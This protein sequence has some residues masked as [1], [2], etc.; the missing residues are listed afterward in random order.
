MSKNH[1]LGLAICVLSSGLLAA[2]TAEELVAKNT[3]AKGGLAK[4]K[5]IRTLRMTGKIQS[6]SFV[7]KVRVDSMR[8]EFLRQ[9][10]TIQGMSAIEAYDGSSG[11][12]ISPFE[13]RKDPELLGEDD[14]KPLIEEADFYGPLIDYKEK[15]NRIEYLG[16]DS[17]DGDDAYR[18]KVTLHNGDIIYYYLDPDTYLE[19]RTEKQV[20]V[21]GAVRESFMEYGSYKKVAGVY[22]PFSLE[23]GSKENAGFRSKMTLDA[24]EAN[25]PMDE[26]E[27]RMPQTGAVKT[28]G[29]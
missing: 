21:R 24:I 9:S 3:E 23:M 16:H 15:G 20:F 6:G 7:V 19:I 26:S 11:W 27:F 1:I 22:Y 17:V 28:S 5:A 8:P 25:V 2:Q 4:I 14:L 29:K 13:G 10:S 12:R 18:L